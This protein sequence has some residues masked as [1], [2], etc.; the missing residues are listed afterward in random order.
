MQVLKKSLQMILRKKTDENIDPDDMFVGD[1]SD[2]LEKTHE[3]LLKNRN[4][5][6]EQRIADEKIKE[7]DRLNKEKLDQAKK[8]SKPS[9]QRDQSDYVKRMFADRL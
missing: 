7:Q 5:L 1:L 3:E 6:R 9:Q 4:N 8:N 2:D